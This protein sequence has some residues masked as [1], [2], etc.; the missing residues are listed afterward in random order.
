MRRIIESNLV[1]E[2]NAFSF[3]V[4]DGAELF[5]VDGVDEVGDF[6]AALSELVLFGAVSVGDHVGAH[7]NPYLAV[8]ALGDFLHFATVSREDDVQNFIAL[9]LADAEA[10]VHWNFRLDLLDAD[11]N[12]SNF[13][14]L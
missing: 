9:F 13:V 2:I 12:W 7:G 5:K 10:S 1:A 8:E 4:P 3:D 6:L 14:L 11:W